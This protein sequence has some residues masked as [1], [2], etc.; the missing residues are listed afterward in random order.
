VFEVLEHT[1]DVGLRV[2]APELDLLFA[3]AARGLFSLIVVRP[4]AVEACQQLEITLPAAATDDLLVDWL[5]E[6]L[7]VFESQRLVLSD[8]QVGVDSRGLRAVV[9]GAPLDV[10]QHEVGYEVKAVTYHRLCVTQDTAGWMA[11]FYLDL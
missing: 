2:R 11:E 5:S 7:F 3:E 9:R 1:A 6:L 8:F 4:A 10:R